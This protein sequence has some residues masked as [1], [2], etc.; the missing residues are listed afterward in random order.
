[1]GRYVYG[2]DI[3]S[4]PN[5]HYGAWANADGASHKELDLEARYVVQ[6]GPAKDMRVRLRRGMHNAIGGQ[7]DGD[8]TMNILVVEWPLRIF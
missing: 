3:T 5:P 8:I 7:P 6:S 1:M 2:Y 4:S